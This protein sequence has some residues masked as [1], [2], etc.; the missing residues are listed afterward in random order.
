M[1][2]DDMFA[3]FTEQVYSSTLLMDDIQVT[4]DFS[5]LDMK[6]MYVFMVFVLGFILYFIKFNGVNSF[7]DAGEKIK[8]GFGMKHDEIADR[9]NRL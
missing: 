9:R 8:I 3:W 4:K 2:V 6:L 7:S 1:I 5:M